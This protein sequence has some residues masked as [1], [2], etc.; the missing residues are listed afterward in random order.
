MF[1][2]RP[3]SPRASA[4]RARAVHTQELPLVIRHRRHHRIDL[5]RLSDEVHIECA[6]HNSCMGRLIQVQANEMPPI[7]RQNN[8]RLICCQL[9]DRVIRYTPSTDTCLG[10]RE[11]IMPEAPERF[12][13]REREV[14]I[15][16]Q[17][18]HSLC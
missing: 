8:P 2:G 16:E 17:P 4:S 18:C 14:L 12:N 11:H 13:D 1:K 9:Q 10:S 6:D 5:F 3:S 15:G 7:E